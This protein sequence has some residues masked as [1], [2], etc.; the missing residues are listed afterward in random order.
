M[1][2]VLIEAGHDVGGTWYWNRYPGAR[3][4]VESVEYSIDS[5]GIQEEWDW[6]ERY[7]GQPEVEQYLRFVADRWQLRSNMHF[8][9][10]LTSATFDEHSATWLLELRAELD[11]SAELVRLSA[12][13]LVLA[14]GYL[15]RPVWPG[16]AGLDD[17]EGLRL[18]TASWPSEQVTVADRRVGIIGTGASGVQVIQTIAPH[19]GHLTVFQRSAVWAVPLGNEAMDP[20][21]LAWVRAH[22]SEIRH[23]QLRVPGGGQVLRQKQLSFPR[24]TEMAVDAT[25][26]ARTNEWETRWAG[27]GLH[28]PSSYGDLLTDEAAN[29]FLREFW[30]GKIRMVVRD[31]VT[32]QKLIPKYPPLTRRT[33]GEHGYFEAFNRANVDLIDIAEDPIAR[34]TAGGVRLESGTEVDLDVLICATGFDAGGGAALG[35]DIIGRGGAALSEHWRDGVRTF[36]GVMIHQFPNLYLINGPQSP[37]PFYNPPML[38]KFQLSYLDELWQLAE[39]LGAV[40]GRAHP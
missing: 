35:I 3:V 22:Y 6:S 7:A 28:L 14:T 18:H 17:F 26:D 23:H 40:D 11:P 10:R 1:R 19:V 15:S 8:G 38:A 9:V 20:D 16:I 30:E 21:Y 29:E 32:A 31:P 5:P 4:D 12:A 39:S 13:H 24:T 25:H 2:A 27:G 33:A 34:V 36:L 37:G